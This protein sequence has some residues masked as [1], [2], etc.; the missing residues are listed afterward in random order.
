MTDVES[1][2][3]STNTVHLKIE[4]NAN[5]TNNTRTNVFDTLEKELLTSDVDTTLTNKNE[6]GNN[7]NNP[8]ISSHPTS[9]S[10]R[11][12]NIP[13]IHNYD[14]VE[15]SARNHSVDSTIAKCS[16]FESLLETKDHLFKE[17]S[18]IEESMLNYFKNLRTNFEKESATLSKQIQIHPE[19]INGCK[20]IDRC[21]DDS[22]TAAPVT[23]EYAEETAALVGDY[24]GGDCNWY[25]NNSTDNEEFT[26]ATNDKNGEDNYC[27]D[28]DYYGRYWELFPDDTEMSDGMRYLKSNR[29]NRHNAIGSTIEKLPKQ[30]HRQK[31]DHYYN[32]V[33]G[34]QQESAVDEKLLWNQNCLRPSDNSQRRDEAT[35]KTSRETRYLKEVVNRGNIT[36]NRPCSNVQI[37]NNKDS[38]HWFY[39]LLDEDS[40]QEL[41]A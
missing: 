23:F 6:L 25:H 13:P 3:E 17:L 26:T 29:N 4:Q 15:D 9:E 16:S 18:T 33:D 36:E 30:N 11:Y 10:H 5:Q 24:E 31:N 21:H 32:S 14:L 27:D 37:E 2:D 7:D 34:D 40:S 28:E 19:S 41:I 8:T 35:R 12:D 38:S 22:C 39:S 20:N 1:S